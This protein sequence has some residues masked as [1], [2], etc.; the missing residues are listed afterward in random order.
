MGSLYAT[1]LAEALS[2]TATAT[3]FCIETLQRIHTIGAIVSGDAAYHA[4]LYTTVSSS[5]LQSFLWPCVSTALLSLS[6]R[7][8]RPAAKTLG[9]LEIEHAYA[10]D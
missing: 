3:D 2:F 6:V 7:I 5:L 4:S 1:A 9:C 8:G 10:L